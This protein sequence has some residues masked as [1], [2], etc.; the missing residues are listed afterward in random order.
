VRTLLSYIAGSRLQAITVAAVC[1]V[2][3][4]F[5]PL[6]YVSAAVVGLAALR[7]GIAE[8]AVIG[9][10]T[11]A[12]A[13]TLSLLAL[14]SAVPVLVFA[15]GLWLPT[16][17]LAG[18]L[19]HS[20]SQGTMVAAAGLG[21]AIGVLVVH[22]SLDDPAAWWRDTLEESVGRIVAG[23]SG[24]LDGQAT[25]NLGRVLDAWSEMMT[26]MLGGAIV[27]GLVVTLL[28][29]RWWH[30]VL[31]YPGGFGREFRALR[32]GRRVAWA[33]IG[34]GALAMF[35]DDVT[36]GVA[37]DL[38]WPAAIMYMFQGLALVHAMVAL[39]G[40]SAAW[41]ITLYVLLVLLFQVVM[42]VLAVVGFLDT[43]FDFRSRWGRGTGSA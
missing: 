19:R 28:L 21:G 32:V 16:V 14:G 12:L 34:V 4:Q 26:G 30:S 6:P 7:R 8:G 25:A 15:L 43:W 29:A 41:L 31:D 17:L 23:G 40:A 3:W 13:G 24:A 33:V 42:A 35:A 20:E 11:A 5:P 36:G 2:L 22:A 10:G 37:T 39:Q 38:I 1:A 9:A 27:M 18:L